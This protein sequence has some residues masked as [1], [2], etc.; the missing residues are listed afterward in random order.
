L[1][2]FLRGAD[3]DLIYNLTIYNL[4]MSYCKKYNIMPTVPY[5]LACKDCLPPSKRIGGRMC[6]NEV[7]DKTDL[8]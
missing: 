8:P 5:C 2:R 3:T 1:L 4:T 6:E 7:M